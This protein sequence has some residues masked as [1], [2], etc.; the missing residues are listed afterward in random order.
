MAYFSRDLDNRGMATDEEMKEFLSSMS[1]EIRM[2]KRPLKGDPTKYSKNLV[3]Y[4]T[5]FTGKYYNY[6]KRYEN[7]QKKGLGGRTIYMG[8]AL[9]RGKKNGGKFKLRLPWLFRKHDK[10][11]YEQDPDNP[12]RHIGYPHSPDEWKKRGFYRQQWVFPIRTGQ[13]VRLK[14]RN[15]NRYSGCDMNYYYVGREQSHRHKHKQFVRRAFCFCLTPTE[16]RRG[17]KVIPDIDGYL[18]TNYNGENSI[19]TNTN[20]HQRI[21]SDGVCGY[22]EF[23][24]NTRYYTANCLRG[25]YYLTHDNPLKY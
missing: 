9:R 2:E 24:N 14:K 25:P 16:A 7:H 4:F 19:E 23:I 22:A 1:F 18:S 6:V 12:S 10:C 3:L 11:Y 20:R 17:F 13:K 8:I 5:P 15:Y 21:I